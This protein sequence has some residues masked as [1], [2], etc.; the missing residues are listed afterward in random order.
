MSDTCPA[1]TGDEQSLQ[2]GMSK[3][4]RNKDIRIDILKTL[5]TATFNTRHLKIGEMPI[6]EMA[7][8]YEALH[9]PDIVSNI[10]MIILCLNNH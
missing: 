1:I 10:L 6:R 9:L 4:M 7:Q 3:E 8:M 2:E 5:M